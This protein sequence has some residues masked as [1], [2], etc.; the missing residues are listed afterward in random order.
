MEKNKSKLSRNLGIA[1]IILSFISPILA[2]VSGTIGLR[3]KMEDPKRDRN[4]NWVGI[5]MAM[6]FLIYKT[7]PII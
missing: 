7:M 3:V 5:T 4:L 1:S 6:V 2:I